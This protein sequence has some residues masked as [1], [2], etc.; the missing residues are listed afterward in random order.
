MHADRQ[1]AAHRLGTEQ[2]RVA[3]YV[4]RSVARSVD[5]AGD[6]TSEVALVSVSHHLRLWEG[7][8]KEDLQIRHAWQC[9]R[10]A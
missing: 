1:N 4:V 8:L 9:Q 5:E 7:G 10:R 2:D 3:G 6:G